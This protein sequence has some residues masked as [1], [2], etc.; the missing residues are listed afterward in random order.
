MKPKEVTK[1]GKSPLSSPLA[2]VNPHR[3]L[4]CKATQAQ[5]LPVGKR[6]AFLLEALLQKALIAAS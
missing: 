3:L 6:L 1:E 5:T 4:L 2:P